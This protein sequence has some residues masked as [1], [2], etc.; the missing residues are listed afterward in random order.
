[1]SENKTK[2][3]NE[4][5]ELKIDNI[6]NELFNTVILSK[7]NKEINVKS[8]IKN[9]EIIIN[10]LYSI[11]DKYKQK[12]KHEYIKDTINLIF[13]EDNIK[14]LIL[15]FLTGDEELLTEI[16]KTQYNIITAFLE[17][18]SALEDEDLNLLLNNIFKTAYNTNNN[19]YIYLDSLISIFILVYYLITVFVSFDNKNI[20][21]IN[22]NNNENEEEINNKK[23]FFNLCYL[24]SRYKNTKYPLSLINSLCNT[25]GSVLKISLLLFIHDFI[26]NNIVYYI[27]HLLILKQIKN[28]ENNV[29]IVSKLNIFYSTIPQEVYKKTISDTCMILE[30]NL[31]DISSFI[32][33]L[34]IKDST[35]LNNS[36]LIIE[37]A[38]YRLIIIFLKLF[39]QKYLK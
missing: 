2:L 10:F 22:N 12:N 3:S 20:L 17:Y 30:R 35:E 16:I 21:N 25:E 6:I 31:A 7:E 9:K 8:L 37:L 39:C 24:S 1:M 32:N 18:I 14:N 27:I 33:K 19:E 36:E 4:L 29:D 5:L 26:I 38:L 34:S 13:I 28:T 11:L 15:A 23:I